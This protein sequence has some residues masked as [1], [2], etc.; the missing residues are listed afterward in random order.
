MS[1][2]NFD[3]LRRVGRDFSGLSEEYGKRITTRPGRTLIYHLVQPLVQYCTTHWINLVNID[4][5]QFSIS[6]LK[7][8]LLIISA[9]KG[10]QRVRYWLMFYC[11]SPGERLNTGNTSSSVTLFWGKK[12]AILLCYGGRDQQACAKLKGGRVLGHFSM[13]TMQ[14]FSNKDAR[15]LH[16]THQTT[17]FF[18]LCYCSP[19]ISPPFLQTQRRPTGAGRAVWEEKCLWSV[20]WIMV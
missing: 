19:Q 3:P 17:L 9:I 1:A 14:R 13:K 5:T 4:F 15:S 6:N 11:H 18:F 20:C 12:R 2:F 16:T 8:Y 10:C 7:S